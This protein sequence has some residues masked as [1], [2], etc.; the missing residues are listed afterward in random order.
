MQVLVVYYSRTGH[1]KKIGD[2]I[3]KE[4]GCDTEEI[5]DTVNRSGPIGWLNSG[6]QAMNKELT[7]L[8]PI[9]KDPA[10]Y[11]LVIVGTPIWSFD[12]SVPV[13]TYLTE[14]KDKLKKVAFFCTEGN[15]GDDT[16]FK[17]MGELCDKKPAGT[18]AVMVK[19]I[20]EG[21]Y[22]DMVKKFVEVIKAA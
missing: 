15:R 20:S 8:K 18:L 17:T 13:R 11:D 22:G 10:G 5:I 1:T 19:D 16:A 12:V 21:N 14:N 9:Q 4:L 3:A 2:D 6:R 7:R